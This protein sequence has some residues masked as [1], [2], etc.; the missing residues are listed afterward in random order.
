MGQWLRQWNGKFFPRSKT[1]KIQNG[2][3]TCDNTTWNAEEWAAKRG[4]AEH[5][6][7]DMWRQQTWDKFKASKRREVDTLK[8]A[9]EIGY[10]R[11]AVNGARKLYREDGVSASSRKIMEGGAI[12]CQ[13]VNIWRKEPD[14]LGCPLCG[15]DDVIPSWIHVAWECNGCKEGRPKRPTSIKQ[16]RWGWPRTEKVTTY[17]RNL[18]QYLGNIRLLV[19]A[20]H[21]KDIVKRST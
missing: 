15:R 7:R 19:L 16:L 11:S 1:W 2:D 21:R 12:S 17:D 20:M 4:K 5:S 10:D 13:I 18:L 3:T 8:E 14:R 9:G 6:M